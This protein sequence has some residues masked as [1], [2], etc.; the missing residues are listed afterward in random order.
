MDAVLAY[1]RRRVR[2]V[3]DAEEIAAEVFSVAWRRR[4]AIPADPLPWLYGVAR[5]AVLNHNRGRRR[6]AALLAR[7]RDEPQWPGLCNPDPATVACADRPVLRCIAALDEPEREMLLLV[8]WEG[9]THDRAAAAMDM[10]R[11]TFSR[12]HAQARDRL[13]A[14]L[15]E[16]DA[17]AA[18]VC[19]T[20]TGGSTDG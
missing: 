3:H 4:E 20:A 9:L 15:A 14:L 2:S 7:L 19:P 17:A 10:S 16:S 13:A 18:N 11:P 1:A 12:R 8:A 6:Q 5:N